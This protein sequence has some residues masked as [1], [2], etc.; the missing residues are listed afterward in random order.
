MPRQPTNFRELL[1]KVGDKGRVVRQSFCASHEFHQHHGEMDGVARHRPNF[2]ENY[3]KV[4]VM[5]GVARQGFNIRDFII[6]SLARR[7]T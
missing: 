7:L 4:G 6:N 1:P 3:A 2:R 5:N